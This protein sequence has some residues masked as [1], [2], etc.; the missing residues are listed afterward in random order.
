MAT[1]SC[2]RLIMGKV[3]I[4]IYCCLTAD[5]LTKVLQKC[6][7]RSPVPNL[8]VLFKPLHLIG[9]MAIERLNFRNSAIICEKIFKNH[10]LRS[11]KGDEAMFI[12]LAS[13]KCMFFIAVAHVLLLLWQHSFNWLIMGKMKSLLLSHCRYFN[14]S[15]T[16]M[17]LEYSTKPI[18]FVQIAVL[19]DCHGN[20]KAK[21]VKKIL[22]NHFLWSHWADEAETL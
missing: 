6:S 12:T 18:N 5:I 15:F 16:E 20:R 1:Y 9:C 7:F 3:K 4:G 8:S 19:I 2:H 17:F 10:L 14:K 22:K 13:I 11:H 21:F